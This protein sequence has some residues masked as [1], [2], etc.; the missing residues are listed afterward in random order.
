MSDLKN[1]GF[2]P[3]YFYGFGPN[4]EPLAVLK[5]EGLDANGNVRKETWIE[6]APP[7]ALDH[8]PI[9]REL[10]DAHDAEGNPLIGSWITNLGPNTLTTVR[11]SVRSC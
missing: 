6:R 4:N 3:G 2:D 7:V 11:I 8:G 10:L 5:V 1:R 9:T